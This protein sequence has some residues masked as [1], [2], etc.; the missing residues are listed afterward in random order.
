MEKTKNKIGKIGLLAATLA[1]MMGTSS[2]ANKPLGQMGGVPVESEVLQSSLVEQSGLYQAKL[3]SRYSV[4]LQPQVLGQ[5]ASIN[6]KAG[7]H[8]RA[9]QT[10]MVVDPR[11]QDAALN[12]SLADASSSQAAISQ[13]QSLLYNYQ[14]QRRALVSNVTLNKQLYDRYS[15]LYTKK[16]VSR[17]DFEKYTD[18]YNKAQS[19]LDANFAQIK[20]QKAAIEAAKSN[21]RKSVYTVKEQ[22]VQ[23]QYYRIT[24]PFS[25]TI[26]DIP[27]KLG[28]SVDSSTKLLS[29]TQ[30]DNLEINVGLPV[31]KIFDIKAG[32]PVEVLDNNENIVGKSTISFIA[33]NVDTATQTVLTKSILKNQTGILKADQSVKVRVVYKKAPGILVAPAAV[34]HLG[35]QDFVFKIIQKGKQNFV[36]QLPVK[37]GSLQEGKYI[38]TNGLKA[39]DEIVSQGI[40]KLMDGAPVT[41]IGKGK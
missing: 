7:D 29:I 32:L 9:G 12:S 17:Q 10:L 39:N 41:I 31:E 27:V 4:T 36:K 26:G 5:I 2:C 16:S 6:V 15:E 35:G 37:L 11:K 13:A 18:S 25:G 30:N 21:Y 38:V 20:A 33:P 28:N 3:I 24:A 19:D 34:S 40:Q 22:Q 1:I 8:V 14:V 23:L